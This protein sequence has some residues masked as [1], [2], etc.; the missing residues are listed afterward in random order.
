ME[1]VYEPVKIARDRLGSIFLEVHHDVYQG[2]PVELESVLARLRAAG[3]GDRVDWS[4]VAEVVA[5][6]WGTPEDVTLRAASPAT[7]EPTAWDAR[8]AAAP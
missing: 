8:P 4:R 5:R 1:V 6:T 3:L 7:A 2:K